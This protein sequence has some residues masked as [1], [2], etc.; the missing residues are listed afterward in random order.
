M[1]DL[2]DRFK[3]HFASWLQVYD[4]D[5]R[6]DYFIGERK[7]V[8]S[9][10]YYAAFC[11]LYDLAERLIMK[12]PEQ[13]NAAGGFNLAPLPAA[14][15]MNHFLVANLLHKHGAV[16]DVRGDADWTPLH[17]ASYC[18]SVDITRWL[19]DHNAG[20]NA[21][22]RYSRTPLHMAARKT[23]V[24]IVQVLLE[25]NPE[26]DARDNEMGKTPLHD[27]LTLVD[28]FPHAKPVETMR[29]LLEHGADPN[30]RDDSD[31][32]PLH[33]ASSLGWLE[34]ARLLLNH[35]ANVD[36]K[37]GNSQTPFEVAASKKFHK[38]TKLLLEHGAVPPLYVV[39]TSTSQYL[40]L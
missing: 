33:R 40:R 10:L 13:V 19:L 28:F 30:T 4:M 17:L 21:R 9:P 25:H 11:G 27:V 7:R 1:D 35:G 5:K 3:P 8:G 12:H 14:L 24:K 26:I 16:V 36:E 38:L 39:Y 6:W 31:S 15:S 37:D 32:T 34:I 23:D 22:N 2:F 18:G 20:A 29:L